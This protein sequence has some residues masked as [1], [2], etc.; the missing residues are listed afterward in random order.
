MP[1]AKGKN[2]PETALP[3]LE[4]VPTG[5]SGVD[6]IT[7]GGLPK[8]RPTLVCGNAGCG[9]T[10]FAME[11]IV[12]GATQ[13]NEPGVFMAFEESE[14]ELTTNVASLGF[15]LDDLVARNMLVVDQVRVER[16]EIEEAGEYDLEGLFIRLG[17]AIDSVGAK[18][19]VLDSLETIFS[20]FMDTAI[21]R[22]ELRR[23]FRWMKERGV[24]AV[25]TA[26][27]ESDSPRLTRY[28]IE[29]FVADCV[30]LLDNRVVEQVSTRRLRV[31]KYRGSAHGANEY[32]F[33][34][35]RQGISVLPITSLGL[36]YR[37]ST[38]RIS[39]GVPRLDAMLGGGYYR[40]SSILISGTAGTGKSSLAITFTQTVCARGER[41][42]YFAFEEAPDQIIRNMRSIG[43]DLQPYVDKGL[44]E[45]RA[46]RPTFTGLEMHLL[47]IHDAVNEF[48]P[49]VVVIDPITG[50]TSV[51]QVLE[52]KA[53]L[54]RLIDFLKMNQI[55]SLFTSLTSGE[56]QGTQVE[57]TETEVSS[58]IDTWILLR[59]LEQNGERNR[60]LYILKSRGMAHSNQAREFLLTDDGIRIE[61]VYIGPGQVL[62]GSARRAQEVRDRQEA[63]A[64]EQEAER[65]RR[66]MERRRGELQAQIASLQDELQSQ[67]EDIQQLTVRHTQLEKLEEQRKEDLSRLRKADV[68]S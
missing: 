18:R 59:N 30:I 31:V 39:S 67:E 48:K 53:M 35:S 40:G 20:G 1:K 14:K 29:E 43:I 61:D 45:F 26:E 13:F 65:R 3:V 62:T 38:D 57:T 60:T 68:S 24:T 42:L 58:L 63:E 51:G 22:S 41:C 32:P 34:I 27:R 66:E 11:F 47:T 46:V 5:I 56:R 4:K 54:S 49:G 37:V 15:D 10:L 17:F 33:L 21:L 52:I 28:G 19:V 44:L 9:K 23:L 16:S 6:E 8:G 12:R 55:T 36:N 50:F 25:V 7:L 64:S 2:K